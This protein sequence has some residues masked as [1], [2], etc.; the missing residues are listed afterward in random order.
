M[1][2]RLENGDPASL[3]SVAD[4]AHGRHPDEAAP[5]HLATWTARAESS[6]VLPAGAKELRVP[7]T[8]TDGQGLTVTKTFVFKR[9]W[10]AIE[11]LYDVHNDSTAAAARSPPTGRSCGTGSMHR[12]RISMSRPIR[13]RVPTVSTARNLAT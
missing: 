2:V 10:Y 11:L 5:T 9:G 6:Y 4:R 1:P 8:W 7:M 13:S 3:V 12:A